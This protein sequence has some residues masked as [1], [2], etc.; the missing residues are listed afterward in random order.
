[1]FV[2]FLIC[3]CMYICIVTWVLLYVCTYVCKTFTYTYT[4]SYT[5]LSSIRFRISEYPTPVPLCSSTFCFSEMNVFEC[6][7]C[8]WWCLA[9]SGIE[10]S[11]RAR[12]GDGE[13]PA[14]VGCWGRRPSWRTITYLDAQNKRLRPHVHGA[15][16]YRQ[17]LYSSFLLPSF[18][19]P[20]DSV[21]L[22]LFLFV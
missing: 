2:W 15:P 16:N 1:M 6:C 20:Y 4:Y 18:L 21:F 5:Y 11:L 8:W 17:V 13:T 7:C 22:F 9:H 19:P 12:V 10:S 3:I 14:G